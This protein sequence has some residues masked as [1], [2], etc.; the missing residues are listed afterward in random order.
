MATFARAAASDPMRTWRDADRRDNAV[1]GCE[2]FFALSARLGEMRVIRR[3]EADAIK[4][5]L[6][7]ASNGQI[8]IE[9][10]YIQFR[11]RTGD[12][13]QFYLRVELALP[14]NLQ[15]LKY[16]RFQANIIINDRHHPFFVF[17]H[18]ATSVELE[19][20]DDSE[21]L[22]DDDRYVKI[23]LEDTEGF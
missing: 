2:H 20:W 4:L 19:K 1:E 15:E 10:T 14:I 18:S 16:R 7:G 11:G 3:C 23:V 12:G 6:Y 9:P 22:P 13:A 8:S 5:A 17:V 21:L